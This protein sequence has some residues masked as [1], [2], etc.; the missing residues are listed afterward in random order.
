MAKNVGSGIGSPGQDK[1]STPKSV[2]DLA[3]ARVRINSRTRPSQENLL[4]ELDEVRSLLD[5][6]L[7]AEAKSRITLLIAAAQG[8]PNVLALARCALSTALEMQGQYRE[9]LAAVAMYESPESRAKL[10]TQTIQ[11]L[12]VQIGL[13]YNYNGDHPKAISILK[14]AL[15]ETPDGENEH[16][17][18]EHNNG[19]V[20]AA[21]ARVYRSI[22]EHPIALDYAQRALEHFRQTG[23]WRGLSE[24]YFGIGLA[25]L[26]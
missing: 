8:N 23:A 10:D 7:S 19:P 24:A 11:S 26:Q 15:R 3:D 18:G 1:S 13:A 25:Q 5:Q 4:A 6:G 21:L 16:A 12:K 2:V 22:A 20:Y 14:G 9:S 17:N